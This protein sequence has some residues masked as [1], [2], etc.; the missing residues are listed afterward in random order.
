MLDQVF[1]FL[2][3]DSSN[4]VARLC[5]LLSIASVSTDPAYQGEVNKG[6]AWV[7]DQLT[8]LGLETKVH[9]TAGHPA[10]VAQSRADDVANPGGQRVLFYGHYDV[11]PPDPLE[12]WDTPPFEPTIRDDRIYAR[13]SSDDKGQIMC[14]IEALRAWKQGSADGKLPGP[15]T[16]LIE[17]EE[18]C[19]S[20]NL[21]P[22]VEANKDLLAAD[23]A[24]VSDTA[25]WAAKEDR[26][27]VV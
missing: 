2:E 7:A 11:Q 3:S 14:F 22:F 21:P 8:E 12:L 18:E 10:V 5:D 16:V 23:I 4:A 9:E 13:G 19:G 1:Q 25:M 24:L 6:A 15:V 27:S 17:G 26:K 20:V